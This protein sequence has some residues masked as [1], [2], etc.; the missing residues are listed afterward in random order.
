MVPFP[1][2]SRRSR[3]LP[4]V[5]ALMLSGGALLL[6]A[7]SAAAE[8]VSGPTQILV[9]GNMGE[10]VAV[11]VDAGT[12]V[13]FVCQPKGGYIA[14][15]AS[16]S[17]ESASFIATENEPTLMSIAPQGSDEQVLGS[18]SWTA[19]VQPTLGQTSMTVMCFYPLGVSQASA[20]QKVTTGKRAA[21]AR[22]TD[23]TDPV[24]VRAGSNL[25]SSVQVSGSSEVSSRVRIPT[26]TVQFYIDETTVGAP[27]PLNEEGVAKG[28]I[29]VPTE[30]RPYV[31][32]FTYSGDEAFSEATSEDR[33]E[34]TVVAHAPTAIE[35]ASTLTQPVATPLTLK[36]LVISKGLHP[37]DFVAVTS[38]DAT[39]G[40]GGVREDGTVSVPVG[41]LAIGTHTLTLSYAGDSY[42]LPSTATVT[43]TVAGEPARS[44]DKPNVGVVLD[45]PTPAVLV[46]GSANL[47]AD[48][49]DAGETVAFFLHSDPVYLGT[50]V[51]DGQ[52]H[53][54][55]LV[56][57]P[58]GVPT[59]QHTA[60]A[61][62]GTSGRWATTAITVST[63]MVAPPVVSPPAEEPEATVV[64]VATAVSVKAIAAQTTL[65]AGA[66]TLA[67]TGA[68]PVG[69]ATGALALM[70][71]GMVLVAWVR[72]S[73]ATEPDQD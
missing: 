60:I 3:V 73:P 26:G 68:Q 19:A 29:P 7:T 5:L 51:A 50:V 52:G 72:R 62:G 21:S 2:P 63:P 10:V 61:T 40:S 38:G 70:L 53:A 30:A 44:T 6:G 45:T 67:A 54:R 8:P 42:N 37:S 12:S 47:L 22:F 43:V 25:L 32:T 1:R 28:S 34:F 16:V 4:S 9:N 36:A 11:T 64:P 27:V 59:G 57:L 46:G 65:A 31:L 69:V 71:V 14:T 56:T 13:N 66:A 15:A 49:F 48:G 35:T 41:V 20:I 58:A 39:L 24:Q 23:G 17:W 55:L 33:Q 18:T